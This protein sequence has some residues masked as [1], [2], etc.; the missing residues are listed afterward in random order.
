MRQ[1]PKIWAYQELLSNQGALNVQ[2]IMLQQT[3]P[4]RREPTTSSA[5]SAEETTRL[6]TGVLSVQGT[7]KNHVSYR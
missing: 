1:V 4:V 5:F 6:I 7:P 2:M 3:A